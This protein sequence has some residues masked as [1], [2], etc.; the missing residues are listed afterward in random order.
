VLT[1]DVVLGRHCVVMPNATLTHDDVLGDFVTVCAGVTLAG[2]VHVGDG[3]YLGASSSVRQGLTVGLWSTLGMGAVCLA[4]VP[5][6][7]VWV[8]NPA[9]SLDSTSPRAVSAAS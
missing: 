8:G 6:H 4:D 1:A 3:A 7:Q 5:A 9:H 2:R